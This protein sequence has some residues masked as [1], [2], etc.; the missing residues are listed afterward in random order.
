MFN[1]TTH[2]TQTNVNNTENTYDFNMDSGTVMIQDPNYDPEEQQRIARLRNLENERM[3]KLEQKAR[4]EQEKKAERRNNASM[5]LH[6]WMEDNK[7]LIEKRKQENRQ[8]NEITKDGGVTYKNSWDKIT[9]NVALKDGEYPGTKDV[10]KF[11]QALL[12][13]RSDAGKK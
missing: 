10:S 7:K 3:F 5:E 9:A 2:T 4:I 12:N 13:K 8:Q 1:Q 6:Q 11:R